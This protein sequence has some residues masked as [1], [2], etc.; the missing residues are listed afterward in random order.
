MISNDERV[1]K[2]VV[3]QLYWDSKVDSSNVK[4]EVSNGV[5]TL[6]GTL[7]SLSICM[8]AVEDADDVVGV[9][10]VIN[11][12][13]VKT[14][15]MLLVATDEEIKTIVESMLRWSHVIVSYDVDVTVLMGEV[16][17]EGSVSEYW[18]KI[19]AEKIALEAAGTTKVINKLS[20]VPTR[21]KEDMEIAKD[22][23][24]AFDRNV[25]VDAGWVGVKVE[26]G[27][28][29]LS[30]NLPDKRAYRAA[31][32]VAASTSGVIDIINDLQISP[33]KV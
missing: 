12:L 10:S 31:H 7:P 14:P 16:T 13:K 1:K 11:S 28:V 33:R 4:V 26:D 27:K 3:D 22:I 15:E 2:D 25:N 18:E 20:V 29:T 21:K 9:R 5:V 19:K 32:N 6:S 8:A 30:G 23:M 24:A 17:L